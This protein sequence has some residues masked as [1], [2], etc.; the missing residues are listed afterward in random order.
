MT[1]GAPLTLNRPHHNVT[2]LLRLGEGLV[3]GG[4][5]DP[6]GVDAVLVR[7]DHVAIFQQAQVGRVKAGQ[8]GPEDT[9]RP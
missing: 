2:V 6:G 3:R 7:R 4:G 8:I 9:L 5:R 1:R